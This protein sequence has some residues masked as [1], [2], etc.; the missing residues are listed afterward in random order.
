MAGS[1]SVRHTESFT[2]TTPT[3]KSS[4]EKLREAANINK[5]LLSLGNVIRARINGDFVNYRD[6]KLTILL[7]QSL[8]GNTKLAVICCITP[9]LR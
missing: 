6:S 5:S 1:E 3:E 7:R 4:P 2:S 8:S 9:A